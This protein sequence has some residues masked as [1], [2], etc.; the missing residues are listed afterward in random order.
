MTFSVECKR[1]TGICSLMFGTPLPFC[2][3]TAEQSSVQYR[4]SHL[5]LGRGSHSCRV[6]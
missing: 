2:A 1:L 3:S 6:A 4:L 5:H